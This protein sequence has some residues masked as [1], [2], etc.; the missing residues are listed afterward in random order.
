MLVLSISQPK[1]SEIHF[2]P[3]HFFDLVHTLFT[4]ENIH[5]SY[6]IIRRITLACIR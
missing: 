1:N 2:I 3:L 4:F 6:S 5:E